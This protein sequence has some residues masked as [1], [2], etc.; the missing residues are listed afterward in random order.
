M[1]LQLQAEQEAGFPLDIFPSADVDHDTTP[2]DDPANIRPVWSRVLVMSMSDYWLAPS[3]SVRF[4]EALEW[5]FYSRPDAANNF[6]NVC[7]LLKLRKT[8]T[9]VR[10]FIAA[11]CSEVRENPSRAEDLIRELQAIGLRLPR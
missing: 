1:S 4:N 3:S 8:P 11:K 5:I 7:V 6:E 2:D 9:E 10:A